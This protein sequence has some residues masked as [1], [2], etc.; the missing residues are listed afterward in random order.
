MSEDLERNA[1]NEGDPDS[2]VVLIFSELID[3]FDPERAYLRLSTTAKEGAVRT[4]DALAVAF[5]QELT[6][7]TERRNHASTWKERYSGNPTSPTTLDWARLIGACTHPE[8]PDLI[9]GYVGLLI[10]DYKPGRDTRVIAA[11]AVS[12]LLRLG[13]EQDSD[14]YDRANA[15]IAAT[16]LAKRLKMTEEI[17]SGLDGLEG[18]VAISASFASSAPAHAALYESFRHFVLFGGEVTKIRKFAEQAIGSYS[19][20]NAKHDLAMLVIQTATVHERADIARNEADRLL[21]QSP[22]E[23]GLWKERTART[24]LDLAREYGLKDRQGA[25]SRILSAM[26]LDDYDFKVF[27]RSHVLTDQEKAAIRSSMLKLSS[28]EAEAAWAN[29]AAVFPRMDAL[30]DREDPPMSA[31]ASLVTS[32]VV[33]E[34]GHVSSEAS[35]EQERV[36]QRHFELDRLHYEWLYRTA[37]EP[38]I[39]ILLDRKECVEWFDAACERSPLLSE[40]G[41]ARLLSA[42]RSFQR[43]D[44]IGVA[45]KLPTIERA[46]REIAI[47][48]GVSIYSPAGSANKFKTLGGLIV[49]V[50]ATLPSPRLGRLWSFLLTEEHGYNIRNN[51]AHGFVEEVSE[52]AATALIQVYIQLLLLIETE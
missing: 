52:F 39:W 6:E 35:D 45:D 44:W 7:D 21:K 40:I 29:W 20:A 31:L 50:T 41:A 3:V 32:V 27:E 18:I 9:R 8:A 37:L 33:S 28:I 1:S 43:R 12:A 49:D 48:S 34:Q 51:Y 14:L 38:G 30:D 25:A 13:S 42:M 22:S 23:S 17:Q 2:E 36:K 15:T 19:S 24:G 16:Q 26:N 4:R 10:W 46:I 5:A 11:N 47:L